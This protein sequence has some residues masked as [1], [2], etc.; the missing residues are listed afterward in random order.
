MIFPA[1]KSPVVVTEEGVDAPADW[2]NARGESLARQMIAG[3]HAGFNAMLQSNPDVDTLAIL[4]AMLYRDYAQW[5][6]VGRF[7]QEV[8]S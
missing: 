1:L 8:E 3:N 5:K 6:N 7:A 4:Q 2:L